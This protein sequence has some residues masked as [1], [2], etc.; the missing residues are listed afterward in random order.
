M[1]YFPLT[2]SRLDSDSDENPLAASQ[3]KRLLEM[4]GIKYGLGPPAD[5]PAE[6]S[7]FYIHHHLPTNRYYLWVYMADD[8]GNG[9]M[10]LGGYLTT[11]LGKTPFGRLFGH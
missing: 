2:I 6:G 5:P 8:P 11:G 3:G 4:L 1:S 10:P 9:W 7:C